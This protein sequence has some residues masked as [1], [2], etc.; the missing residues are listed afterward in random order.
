ME[1]NKFKIKK[2][3]KSTPFYSPLY[4]SSDNH[5]NLT[6]NLIKNDY[7]TINTNNLYSVKKIS[8]KHNTHKKK[9]K[10]LRAKVP[11][12]NLPAIPT[13]DISKHNILN[14]IQSN[15]NLNKTRNIL[16]ENKIKINLKSIEKNLKGDLL[17]FDSSIKPLYENIKMLKNN[18]KYQ[19]E[20]KKKKNDLNFDYDEN[21]YDIKHNSFSGNDPN[22]LKKKVIFVKNIFDYIYPKIVINRMKFT[23]KQK[24]GEIQSQINN[25]AKKFGNKYYIKRY[26]SPEENSI[27]SKFQLNGAVHDES[28]KMKG[29]FIKLKKVMINGHSATQLAKHCDYINN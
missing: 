19:E 11:F 22:L 24:A 13:N 28:I 10:L 5:L 7:K 1:N 15:N 3:N 14:N 8:Y 17:F 25:L 18:R 20:R 4:H 12:I 9:Y 16:K 29:D 26:K 2:I 21:N 27:F 23:D 6:R